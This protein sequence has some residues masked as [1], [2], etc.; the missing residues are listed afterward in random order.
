MRVILNPS[1]IP[2]RLVPTLAS[3]GYAVVL[4][5]NP[6]FPAVAVETRLR[7][8]GLGMRN[9]VHVTHYE[10]STYC[11]PNPGYFREILG[12][13]AKAPDQCLMVGNTPAEDMSAGVLGISLFLVT[14][15]LENET[16]ADISQYKN[17]TLAE[18]EEYLM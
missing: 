6:L 11:K 9:F 1:D 13:I 15:C 17:G 7:W 3:K 5:T 8:A 18:L 16:G 2:G 14:D 10:N 12:K 4:A